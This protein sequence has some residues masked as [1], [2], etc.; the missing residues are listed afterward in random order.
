MKLRRDKSVAASYDEDGAPVRPVEV[1]EKCLN[2]GVY[3]TVHYP[4]VEKCRNCGDDEYDLSEPP[5]Q[6]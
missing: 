4:I 2:C 6:I 1:V 3:R 5:M